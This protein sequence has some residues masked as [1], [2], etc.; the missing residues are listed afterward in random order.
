[1]DG[2]EP[3][4]TSLV[5]YV[6]KLWSSLKYEVRNGEVPEA[7]QETLS[8]FECLTSRLAKFND[9]EAALADFL[10]QTWKDTAE[11]LE[12]PTY[13]E[14]AGSILISIAGGSVL[15]FC[16]T[17]PRL[18]EAV[19]RNIGQP[20]SPAHSKNL[21]V[22]L[23][24][25]VRT[26]R[27]L[28]AKASE[29]PEHDK[30]A[31]NAAGF[32]IPVAVIDDIYFKLFRESTVDKPTKDQVEI[33]KE[34]IN[35]LSL[36]VQVQ[37]LGADFTTTAAYE[38]DTL[39]EICTA[40]S[41]RATNSF[42]V[43]P[44]A[45]V[46]LYNIDVSAVAALKTVV[47]VFPE[48]Y[49]KVLSNVVGE[50][51]KR[52]WKGTASERTFDDL[53]SVCQRVAYIGCA[54]IPDSET[55]IINFALFAGT[56]LNI[57]SVLFNAEANIKFCAVVADALATGVAYF[58]KAAEDKGLKQ[59]EAIKDDEWKK[60]T[61]ADLERM[62]HAEIP[63][64]PKLRYGQVNL[65][66]PIPSTK[67]IKPAKHSVFTSFRLVGVYVVSELYRHAT[68][69]STS[70][71]G[72]IPLVR[73]SDALRIADNIGGD[74]P[75]ASENLAA[76]LG[77]LG[78][79]A[80]LVLR[81]VS[82]GA[83]IHLDLDKRVADCFN[84]GL[85]WRN[86]SS[87][88]ALFS[89]S[90][91]YALSGGIAQ[92]MHFAIVMIMVGEN[93]PGLS[94]PFG[95]MTCVFLTFRSLQTEFNF[96]N[97]LT[98]N[99]DLP[100]QASPRVEAIQDYTA[101]LVANKFNTGAGGPHQIDIPALQPIWTNVLE[102]IEA[103]LKQPEF[104]ELRE[105][106]RFAAILSG[107]F[108]RRDLPAAALSSTISHA[109]AKAGTEMGPYV[110][111]ILSQLFSTSRKGLLDSANHTVQRPLYLQWTYQQCVQPVLNLA[112]P[113][114]REDTSVVHS[115]YV[116]HA[117]KSLALG[118][119]AD[120]APSIVRIVL[121]AMQKA[122]NSY[123]V[124]AACGVALQILA[125]DPALFRSHVASLV[126]A[127]KGVY[128]RSLPAPAVY[129][130]APAAQDDKEW[131][132]DKEEYARGGRFKYAGDREKIRRMALRTLEVLPAQLDENDLRAY[133]DEVRVHLSVALGDRVRDV[134][135]AA[136]AAQSAWSRIST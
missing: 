97:L 60:W 76:Y 42:N 6:T 77:E 31:F 124:E 71:D 113:L 10:S 135:R 101:F 67:G 8:I 17:N 57:L 134:R 128:G 78:R 106:C 38:Q 34:A 105:I 108:A 50:I 33:A 3:V 21:L 28:T 61:A 65:Y 43:S 85:R 52:T 127:A 70:E 39:K 91:L 83:Q 109:A 131:P 94:P 69:V 27:K 80:C 45:S 22:L 120:D 132:A 48:G 7:I 116:L 29:W 90:E 82:A 24:N 13:T 9:T 107:A 112:Y 55:P 110:A 44:T 100:I 119:Y 88:L 68:A 136:E 56:M 93:D 19:R 47:K 104:L 98:G 2:Y 73:L 15:A 18:L 41:Y 103:G 59:T 1:M 114:S 118:H 63:D 89:D 115:I 62:V 4:D 102:R 81:E 16:R 92:A 35:G 30:R 133:A 72:R 53:H 74:N 121:A 14:Q 12:N 99:L 58:L 129:D 37:R 20:K 111:R 84:S 49:A 36:V 87:P 5:P 117:V 130:R 96:L 66:D 25:L 126:K 11:D 46:E 123:D 75:R 54:D 23:N 64:F 40:L 79:A 86:N 51:E 125:G 95:P 26:H 32:G 122:T